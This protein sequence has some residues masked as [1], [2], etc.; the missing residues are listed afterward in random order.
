MHRVVLTFCAFALGGR[1]RKLAPSAFGV[2]LA[3]VASVACGFGFEDVATRA[4]QLANASFKESD[5][6]LPKELQELDY[7]HFRDI[8]FKP[9]RA[10]WRDAKLP[11]ELASSTWDRTSTAP[12]GSTR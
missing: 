2:L 9:D 8:R 12:C 5:F 7:D 3:A 4:R 11:F 6:K 1:W 10:V